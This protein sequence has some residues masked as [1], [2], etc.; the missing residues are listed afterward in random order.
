MHGLDAGEPLINVH[1]V[2]ERLIEASLILLSH[3]ENLEF[4][5]RAIAEFLETLG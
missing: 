1:R 5:V 4:A 3:E 2:Q